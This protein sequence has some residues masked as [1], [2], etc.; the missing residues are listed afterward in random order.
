[1]GHQQG[2]DRI[3]ASGAV[4]LFRPC[5]W[6]GYRWSRVVGLYT[7]LSRRPRHAGP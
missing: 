4:E 3:P 2:L 6:P 1:V 7:D 5:T